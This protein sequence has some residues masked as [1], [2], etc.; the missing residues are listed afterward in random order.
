[1]LITYL[2]I[3]YQIRKL[4]NIARHNENNEENG[5]NLYQI[6]DWRR[7]VA[8]DTCF[9]GRHAVSTCKWVLGLLGKEDERALQSLKRLCDYNAAGRKI[10][11]DFY[12]L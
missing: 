4:Y 2:T 11:E 7:G 3:L 5:N 6:A 10:A 12:L 1:M 9:L 8:E